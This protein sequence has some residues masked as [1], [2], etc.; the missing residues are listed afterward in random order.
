MCY[1]H[2]YYGAHGADEG[3]F[4]PTQKPIDLYRWLLD[5]FA[6]PGQTILDTH[7]GSMTSARAAHDMGYKMTIIE[8]NPTYYAKAK[9]QLQEF[10]M[11]QKLF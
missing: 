11:I 8:I 9:K 7:G 10:Q 5:K 3:R 6:E 1:D 4:H 2:C